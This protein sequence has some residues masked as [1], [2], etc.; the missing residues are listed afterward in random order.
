MNEVKV[1]S[2]LSRTNKNKGLVLIS[3]RIRVT[4]RVRVRSLYMVDRL[5][6]NSS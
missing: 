1:G 5:P 3:V 6:R 4:V 2:K